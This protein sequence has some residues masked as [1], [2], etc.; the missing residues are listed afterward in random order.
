MFHV[1]Q[2]G[3]AVAIPYFFIGGFKMAQ[4]DWFL[5]IPVYTFIIFS[6]GYILGGGTD[7]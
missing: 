6:L 3:V 7:E 4:I 2:L 1:E 5:A